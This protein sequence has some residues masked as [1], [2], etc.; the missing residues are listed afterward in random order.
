MAGMLVAG[1]VAIAGFVFYVIKCANIDNNSLIITGETKTV[2]LPDCKIVQVF[3]KQDKSEKDRWIHMEGEGLIL[4]PADSLTGSIVYSAGLD[5]YMTMQN[6]GD[7]LNIVWDFSTDKLDKEF[8]NRRWFGVNPSKVVLSIP[9]E[10]EDV[11]V[12]I[13][14][15]TTIFKDFSRDSLSFNVRNTAI[16]ENC[17]F[18]SLNAQAYNLQLK[19]G[20]IG[21][22]YMN[23]DR[24]RKLESDVNNCRIETEH[25]EGSGEHYNQLQ[26]GEAR[27][28]L[29]T[30]LTEKA[31]LKLTLNQAANIEMGN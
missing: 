16:V 5:T 25:L 27:Q 11:T 2:K 1:L 28:V 8:L 4:Q 12:K 31:S 29:W 14:G 6:S 21:N 23:L 26:K 17:C 7:T 9:S 22:L 15:L 18:S 20:E 13:N 19:S 10:V 30:P 3:L 24:V